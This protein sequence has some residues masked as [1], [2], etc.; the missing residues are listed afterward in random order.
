MLNLFY[1][2]SYFILDLLMKWN[3]ASNMPKYSKYL[4]LRMKRIGSSWEKPD[5]PKDNIVPGL[6]TEIIVM[7]FL[8]R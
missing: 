8:Y 5:N 7:F 4:V 2:D 1:L 6:L 3:Q